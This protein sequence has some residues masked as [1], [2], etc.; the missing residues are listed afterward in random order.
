MGN[1]SRAKHYRRY[2]DQHGGKLYCPT[3][4]GRNLLF[5]QVPPTPWLYPTADEAQQH[6]L[7]HAE[8]KKGQI[9]RF[10]DNDEYRNKILARYSKVMAAKIME[11]EK[12][13]KEK[14]NAK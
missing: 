1:L 3:Y 7:R 14:D 8:K 2:D 6:A 12:Q 5:A 9:K 4:R 10:N 11:A 13:D